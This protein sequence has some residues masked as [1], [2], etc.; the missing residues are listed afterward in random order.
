MFNLRAFQSW[1]LIIIGAATISTLFMVIMLMA[2]QMFEGRMRMT[3]AVVGIGVAA[4]LGYV[5]TA[6]LVRRQQPSS[7]NL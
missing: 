1:P 5:A 6:L 4:F 3:R 7:E 2:E